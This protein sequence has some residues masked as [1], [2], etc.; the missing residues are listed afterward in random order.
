MFYDHDGNSNHTPN[1]ILSTYWNNK[2]LKE[3]AAQGVHFSDKPK[4]IFIHLTYNCMQFK[5]HII[6]TNA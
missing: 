4:I 3:C 1:F 2:V 5:F 6:E